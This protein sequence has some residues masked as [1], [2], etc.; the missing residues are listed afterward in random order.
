MSSNFIFV[1]PSNSVDNRV[2]IFPILAGTLFVV[3]ALALIGVTIYVWVKNRSTLIQGSDETRV[4]A[5][6]A[7]LQNDLEDLNKSI[8]ILQAKKGGLSEEDGLFLKGLKYEKCYIYNRIDI[9]SSLKKYNEKY[10]KSPNRSELLILQD[11]AKACIDENSDIGDESKTQIVAARTIYEDFY[12][13]S[14]NRHV[15]DI[16]KTYQLFTSSSGGNSY[17]SDLMEREL[18]YIMYDYGLYDR[19]KYYEKIYGPDEK[20][21]VMRLKDL[22]Y[23]FFITARRIL[24]QDKC[25]AVKITNECE[26]LVTRIIMNMKQ[27]SIDPYST[28]TYTN[29]SG[30]K[31]VL[32]RANKVNEDIVIYRNNANFFGTKY[33]EMLLYHMGFNQDNMNNL[34]SAATL[35]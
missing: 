19:Y 13:M 14:M 10:T 8:S 27:Y 30:Y 24:K 9:Y 25:S 12:T 32:V 15:Q 20:Y 7:Q 22:D 29:L 3:I 18:C 16:V 23:N 33:L 11:E 1:P 6:V 35:P 5:F 21:L 26:S 34:Y 4:M 31:A 2:E 17:I 28:T